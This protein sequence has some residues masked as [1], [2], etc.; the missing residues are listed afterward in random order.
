MD[1]DVSLEGGGAAGAAHV[2]DLE[3]VAAKV[4]RA[5]GL[6]EA[7]LSI[8]LCDDAFIHPLNRDWRGKDRPTDVLSFAQREGEEAD[9]DDPVLGDVVISLETAARQADERGHPL[10][11]ELRVLLVHGIC[12]LLGYD[13]EEDDEAEEM[14]ALERDLLAELP[15]LG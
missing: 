11:H 8:V 9:E 12:H 7:E 15:A 1:I 14:E 2:A 13:H 5:F 10:G 6:D 4:L 3:A